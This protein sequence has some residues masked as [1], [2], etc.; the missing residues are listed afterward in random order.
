ML[1]EKKIGSLGFIKAT[2]NSLS[3]R[4][5]APEKQKQPEKRPGNSLIMDSCE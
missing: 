1:V 3:L 5:N 4:S 2:K